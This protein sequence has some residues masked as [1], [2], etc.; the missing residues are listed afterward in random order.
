MKGSEG[1]QS[2]VQRL[3]MKGSVKT[4]EEHHGS[5]CPFQRE[6]Y[7]SKKGD[8]WHVADCHV[9]PQ[10]ADHNLVVVR[11]CAYCAGCNPPPHRHFYPGGWCINDDIQQWLGEA[12]GQLAPSTS[13]PV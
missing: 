4:H 12:S 7:V 2:S 11:G 10:I 3:G 6:I 13:S 5:M 1:F 8:C 9:T